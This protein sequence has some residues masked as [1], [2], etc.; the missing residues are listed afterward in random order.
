MGN[1]GPI[2][3]G[4]SF[5][6]ATEDLDRI[7]ELVRAADEGGLDLVGIQDHPYQRSGGSSTF[8]A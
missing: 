2:R 4:I 7:H 5:V 3:C 8:R 1:G 6:P